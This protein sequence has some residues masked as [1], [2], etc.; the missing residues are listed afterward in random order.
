MVSTPLHLMWTVNRTAHSRSRGVPKIS[1]IDWS[2]RISTKHSNLHSFAQFYLSFTHQMNRYAWTTWCHSLCKRPAKLGAPRN[3]LPSWSGWC[4]AW[5]LPTR[6]G[7]WKKIWVKSSD[8]RLV[9]WPTWRLILQ[10]QLFRA[11]PPL[12]APRIPLR[13]SRFA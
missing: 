12:G 9:G 7:F 10:R 8:Y 6:R 11:R 5:L 4:W 3:R 13:P 1:S 2:G